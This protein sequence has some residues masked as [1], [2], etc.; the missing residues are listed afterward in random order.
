MYS[1]S[2]NES[3]DSWI[4]KTIFLNHVF[5]NFVVSGE[6]HIL[7]MCPNVEGSPNS[8]NDTKINEI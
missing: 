2:Y 4:E 8:T 5:N 7:T 6:I 3:Y 1:L